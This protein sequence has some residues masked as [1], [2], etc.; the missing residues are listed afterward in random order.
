MDILVFTIFVCLYCKVHTHQIGL[1]PSSSLCISIGWRG[2]RHDKLLSFAFTLVAHVVCIA[3]ALDAKTVY[4]LPLSLIRSPSGGS[5]RG[6]AC[7]LCRPPRQ[8]FLTDPQPAVSANTDA[9]SG[10]ILG[11]CELAAEKDKCLFWDFKG[12][13]IVGFYWLF[14]PLLEWNQS[15]PIPCSL[16][17]YSNLISSSTKKF[18]R[19]HVAK[20]P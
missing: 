15:F 3:T 13:I 5:S 1:K 12:L 7:T 6:F 10:K 11:L 17:S 16:N 19:S 8:P 2:P 18:L 4:L 9:V 20:S 14:I